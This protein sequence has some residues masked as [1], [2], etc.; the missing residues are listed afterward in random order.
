M[1]GGAAGRAESMCSASVPCCGE[2][3]CGVRAGRVGCVGGGGLQ[4]PVFLMKGE[5]WGVV[6]VPGGGGGGVLFGVRGGRFQVL[7]LLCR[8]GVMDGLWEIGRAACRERV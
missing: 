8:R 5:G 6:L 2:V 1:V 3:S 7:Q 4:G